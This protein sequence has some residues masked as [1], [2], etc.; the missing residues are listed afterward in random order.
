MNQKPRSSDDELRLRTLWISWGLATLVVGALIFVIFVNERDQR[1]YAAATGLTKQTAYLGHVL[2]VAL[3]T[4]DYVEA[5][6]QVEA[7]GR[8]HDDVSL[9]QLV[10]DN[11]FVLADFRR[12]LGDARRHHETTELRFSYRDG[13]TLL[14]EKSLEPVH[15][16]MQTLAW[17]L[18]GTF[19][20]L[21]LSV[22]GLLHQFSRYR[23]Q[24]R[25]TAQE[26]QRRLEA[27]HALERMATLDALT[28]LPN[29][30]MLDEQLS[31]RVAEARRFERRLALLFIDLDD[32]KTINDSF[33]H[34]TGDILLKTAARRMLACLRGYDLLAR[35]GGDE[36]VV[37]LSN[38]EDIS[39]IE[40]VASRIN[41]ALTP[42]MIVEERELFISAS[43]GISLFP[44]DAETPGDLLRTADAAMY[45]A[46]E[47][48]RNC[49]RFY[50]ASMNASLSHRHEI[51]TGLHAALEE[52]ALHLVYQPQVDLRTG[53]IRSC[54]AL[55]RWQ[56]DGH[57][58][59]PGEFI[60]I[61]EQSALMKRLQAFVI[62]EAARQR[63]DWQ[64]LGFNALRV[65][66]NVSG[67]KIVV[68]EVAEQLELALQRH[69]LK[70]E[71]IGIELT[72]HTLIE[73]ADHTVDALSRLRHQGLK[74]SLD[75]FGTG[76][77]SLY[78]LKKL[79]V[80]ILKI[81]RSFI[82]DV[83]QGRMDSA[84]VKAIVS[85]GSSM[86]RTTLAEGVE[87]QA[88]LDYVRSVGCDL[89][90]GF[91]LH[92]PMPAAEMTRL[93]ETGPQASS[94]QAISTRRP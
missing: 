9:V 15:R 11:G 28:D 90:Q 39:E 18:V 57:A 30:Y 48:G 88:Q 49:H 14:V 25:L 91:F 10:A 63:A 65:D 46:K 4:G 52:R 73:A 26:Y 2:Q 35:F 82:A 22:L 45:S 29:R 37:L 34:E 32:F 50:T 55:V 92:R 27:Q 23:R 78:Y 68:G 43:I 72:E 84:I 71:H 86:G 94:A 61:A 80:D 53:A 74:V 19:V 21:E 42:R 62:D 85:M 3:G 24:V 69:G 89:A 56:H 51:E 16:A 7:W 38:V 87:T 41:D 67:G 33:G 64:R 47:A 66:V 44:D 36:F 83:P 13:A 59:P 70:H 54:E 77:S 6:Q 79:P 81:D 58:I 8:L 17:Q 1:L 20:I 76:Y 12:S 75:D 5:R 31:L 93:L 40:Y 60:P